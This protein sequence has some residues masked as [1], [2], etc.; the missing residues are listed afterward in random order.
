MQ[1]RIQVIKEHEN[2]NENEMEDFTPTTFTNDTERMYRSSSFCHA[3]YASEN[4]IQARWDLLSEFVRE[5]CA[6][7]GR[8]DSHGHAHMQAVAQQARTIIQ[9]DHIDDTGNLTL[10]AITA[11]WLHDIADHKYDSD[12][13]LQALLDTF[14]N[15]HIWNYPE[16]KQVIK[17]IS[18][19]SENR[20]LLAGTPLD[21]PKIL[22]AYY[23]Q[24]RDIVS[25]A[26][27]LE[28]LGATGVHR[29]IE[30]T[31]QANPAYSRDQVIA[32]VKKHAQ[33]KLLRLASEFIRNPTARAIAKT[34]HNE[35]LATLTSL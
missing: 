26:D 14:G 2:E 34:K 5:T 21:Y 35:M 31:T 18:Y 17:Y 19:S 23:A 28:A 27:K 9:Q 3:T 7:H 24:I 16:I 15:K 1:L 6:I 8:D 32:D 33:E 25:D 10:D 29:A 11:A 22:G 4:T 30:Y 20:A 12:G 13:S